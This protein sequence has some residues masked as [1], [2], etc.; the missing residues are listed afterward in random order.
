[1]P[2]FLE[3]LGV[4][5]TTQPALRSTIDAVIRA[6]ACAQ[7]EVETYTWD[8]LPEEFRSTG[9]V[10]AI[11]REVAWARDAIERAAS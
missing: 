11:A 5:A 7:F 10:T 9:L 3:S 8:V 2:I 4:F 1:M 6:N